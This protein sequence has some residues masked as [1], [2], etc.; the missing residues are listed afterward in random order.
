ML[1]LSTTLVCEELEHMKAKARNRL[2]LEKWKVARERHHSYIARRRE[3]V[4]EAEHRA[5]TTPDKETMIYIDGA[6]QNTTYVPQHW[7]TQLRLEMADNSYL[8]QRI[9][10][11]LIIGKPD[12]LRFYVA[13][14]QVCN[15]ESQLRDW[16]QHN[17]VIILK[18]R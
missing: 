5:R 11:A 15:R 10:S 14:P 7:R 17:L 12:Q 6:D 1:T 8:P 18:F 13:T 3:K 9:M 16:N 4:A 2:D